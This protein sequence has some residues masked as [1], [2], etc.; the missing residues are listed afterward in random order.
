MSTD[1]SPIHSVR[2]VEYWDENLQE[3]ILDP[4]PDMH[5]RPPADIQKGWQPVIPEP[6]KEE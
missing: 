6:M 5:E 2:G 1:R 4:T 3:Y